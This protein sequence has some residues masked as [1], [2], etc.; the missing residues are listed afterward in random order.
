MAGHH[1]PA[2]TLAVYAKLREGDLPEGDRL[3][4]R[5]S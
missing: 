3:G 5:V 1:D 2:F 4:L